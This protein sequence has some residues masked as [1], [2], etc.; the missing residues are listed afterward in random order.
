MNTQDYYTKIRE[1]EQ[2]DV[3]FLHLTSNEPYVSET[4]KA[5]AGSRLADRYYMGGGND[6]MIILA[7][8]RHWACQ[9]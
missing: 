1:D 3:A 4:A 5:F 7:P 6:G 8:L 2:K 9:A